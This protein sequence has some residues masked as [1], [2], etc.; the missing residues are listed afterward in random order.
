MELFNFNLPPPGGRDLSAL[1]R[2]LAS[3]GKP[4][5]LLQDIV[6]KDVFSSDSPHSRAALSSLLTACTRRPVSNPRVINSELLPPILLGKTV[7][8]DLHV[9]FNDGE[10]ADLEMQGRTVHDDQRA[11][12]SYY[13]ARL[14][15]AQ[16]K[17]GRLYGGLK[18]VYQIFF[19]DGVIKRGSGKLGRWYVMMEEEEHEALGG[20][21]E[22]V[23]YELPKAGEKVREWKEGRLGI[24]TLS[25]EEKWCIYMKYRGE[26]GMEG[27]VEELARSDEG[28]MG[29]ERVLEGI[30]WKEEE[31]FARALSRELGEMDYWSALGTAMRD[32]LAKGEKKGLAKS[33]REKLENA[34]KMKADGF[35]IEQIEKYSGLN[36][37]EI[38][39]L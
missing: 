6:F 24:G 32:G 9:I 27:M 20:L 39:G 8:M 4:L 33:R 34:R 22:L 18:R 11:R 15:A 13:G 35:T 29:A 26:E 38:E 25:G 19:L 28:I 37:E 14:L 7:R 21:E 3:Q 2:K 23:Y 10:R 30:N 17:R 36:R 5:S 1:A 31:E 12:G 16:G